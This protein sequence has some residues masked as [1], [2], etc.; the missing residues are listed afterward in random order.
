MSTG[1]EIMF[2]ERFDEVTEIAII[3]I[4]S[5]IKVTYQDAILIG[6]CIAHA[7]F[8]IEGDAMTLA[9]RF[10]LQEYELAALTKDKSFFHKKYDECVRDNFLAYAGE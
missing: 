4:Q 8:E 1:D 5:K 2:A 6:S 7:Y 3:K 10:D 9:N